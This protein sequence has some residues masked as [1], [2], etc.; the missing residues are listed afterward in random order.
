MGKYRTE[1]PVRPTIRDHHT[2]E[3]VADSCADVQGVLDD[4]LHKTPFQKEKKDVVCVLQLPCKVLL[5]ALLL[6]Q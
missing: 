6:S 5:T 2:Q 1:T 3:G 4:L